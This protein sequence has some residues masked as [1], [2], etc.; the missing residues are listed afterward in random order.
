MAL[1]A[2]WMAAGHILRVTERRP[3]VQVKLALGPD[4]SVPR[5]SGGHPHGRRARKRA[6][7]GTS[8]APVPMQSSWGARPSSMTIR[9]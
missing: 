9:C 8:C 2:H 5:G 3:L 4:G 7:K 6:R 1:E